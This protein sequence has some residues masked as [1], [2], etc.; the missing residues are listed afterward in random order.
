MFDTE[1]HSVDAA[2][3]VGIPKHFRQLLQLE[4]GG[5]VH[6]HVE[7]NLLILRPVHAESGR[8]LKKVGKHLVGAGGSKKHD[9]AEDVAADRRARDARA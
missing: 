7:G 6:M 9:A 2:G 5:P 8:R 3:R 1:L 4:G